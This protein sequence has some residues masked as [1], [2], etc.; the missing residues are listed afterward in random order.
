MDYRDRYV[1]GKGKY[2]D[3]LKFDDMLYMDVV[4]SPYGRAKISNA[5]ASTYTSPFIP[6][7]FPSFL[8]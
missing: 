6:V 1:Q 4:R 5:P 8:A 2:I 3:D 7:I